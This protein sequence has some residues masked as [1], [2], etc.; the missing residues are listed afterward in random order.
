MLATTATLPPLH[1]VVLQTEAQARVEFGKYLEAKAIPRA[2]SLLEWLRD[3]KIRL[4]NLEK[5]INQDKEKIEVQLQK[6]YAKYN[7]CMNYY[8]SEVSQE[9]E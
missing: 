7:K 6:E 8:Y 2:Q 9:I 4:E 3:E 5:E 1:S